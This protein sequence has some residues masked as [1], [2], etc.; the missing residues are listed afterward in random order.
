MAGV[1]RNFTCPRSCS[2]AEGDFDLQPHFG[3]RRLGEPFRLTDA[4]SIEDPGHQHLLLNLTKLSKLVQLVVKCS[5][6]VVVGHLVST[7]PWSARGLGL[8]KGPS[9]FFDLSQD[10]ASVWL[11]AAYL[12]L[13]AT[14]AIVIFQWIIMRV[15][16]SVCGKYECCTWQWQA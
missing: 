2:Q 4:E 14:I 13:L 7:A 10:M 15:D 8:M 1:L 6:Q 9:K 3:S 16:F 5:K 12:L 11:V